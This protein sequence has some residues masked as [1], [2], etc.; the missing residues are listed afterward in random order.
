[1]KDAIAGFTPLRRLAQPEDVAGAVLFFCV[2]WAR[3]VT[4]AYLPLSG[5]VQMP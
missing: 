3:F 1:M 2:D 4:G 5:G